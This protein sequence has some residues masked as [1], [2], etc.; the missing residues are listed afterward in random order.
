[1]LS[2]KG[3]KAKNSPNSLRDLVLEDWLVNLVLSGN[4]GLGFGLGSLL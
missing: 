4:M 2:W 3:R 1:M